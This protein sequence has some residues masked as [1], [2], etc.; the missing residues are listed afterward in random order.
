MV[1]IYELRVTDKD[2]LVFNVLTKQH[3]AYTNIKIKSITIDNQ[4]TF[5]ST[6]ASA[7]PV[8]KLTINN[9]TTEEYGFLKEITFKEMIAFNSSF[10]IEDL[11]NSIFY[12]YIEVTGTLTEEVPCG[13]DNI[14]TLGVTYDKRKIYNKGLSYLKELGQSCTIPNGFIDYIL[15]DKAFTLALDTGNYVLV[16]KYWNKYYKNNNIEVTTNGCGCSK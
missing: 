13:M 2:S 5:S 10:S 1:D 15:T 8:Y 12:V 3:N 16:N 6:G 4:D 9:G 7:N 14:I 11:R